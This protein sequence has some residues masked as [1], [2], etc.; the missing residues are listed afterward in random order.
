MHSQ[1]TFRLAVIPAIL[2]AAACGGGDK[3]ASAT[4][5]AA[6]T[7]ASIAVVDTTRAAIFE[8]S[9]VAQPMSDATV[10]TKLMGAVTAVLVTEGAHVA[11][12]APLVRLDAADLDAKSR[13]AAAGIAAAD[14]AHREAQAQ[15]TRIR[16]LYADSAAPR[17]Q[18]DAVEAGLARATAGLEAAR[19]GESE[20]TAVRAYGVLRAPFAGVVTHRFVDVGDFAAPGA[21]LVTVQDASRL[22]ITAALP[23]AMALRVKAGMRLAARIEGVTVQ[24]IVEGVVPSAATM[25]TVNAIVNNHDG[26][27]PSGGAAVLAVPSGAAEQVLL[28]PMDAVVREGDLTGVRVVRDGRGELRWVRLG[29]TQGARVVVLSGLKAGERVA[30]PAAGR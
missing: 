11:A 19:A 15:A 29:D 18:L 26:K 17:A 23:A 9:G 25:Y 3:T 30:L 14:A 12:G 2:L 21:P 27:L 22:R 20:L 24:A 6:E 4:K 16:A 7:S 8:A 28:V 13:Q 5:P 1:I 10:S